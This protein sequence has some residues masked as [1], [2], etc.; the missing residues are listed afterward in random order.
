MAV[1]TGKDTTGVQLVAADGRNI[2]IEMSGLTETATGVEIGDFAGSFTLHSASAIEIG[3][4]NASNFHSNS[5]FHNTGTYGAGTSGKALDMIDILS[6]EGALTAIE[7]I[8]NALEQINEMRGDLGA[9]QNRLD[10]TISNLQ[11]TAENMNASRSR[12]EDADFATES[13][14][15]AKNKIL[16]QASMA[17]LAQANQSAQGVMTLLR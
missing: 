8:D 3:T 16:Q 4:A 15:L 12:I 2:S 10:Y 1:D 11:S 6:S 17:M 5:D 7:A 13:T 9:K 14:A